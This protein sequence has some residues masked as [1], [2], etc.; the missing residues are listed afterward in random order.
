M[1][2]VFIDSSALINRYF[3][4]TDHQ[5]V[6][7]AMDADP[8]WC[9]S[10]IARTEVQLSLH[11]LALG[12]FDQQR[13][14]SRFRD[15]WDHTHVVPVDERLLVRATEVGSQFGLRTIDAIQIAAADRL[16]RPV[17]YLTLEFGQIP[18]AIELGFDVVSQETPDPLP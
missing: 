10:A 11:R 9:V 5:F 17:S 15:D 8:V 16:P 3:D 6:V 18:A 4:D 2:A 12:P 13:L 14:W 1:M 7:D